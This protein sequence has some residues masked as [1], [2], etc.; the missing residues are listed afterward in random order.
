MASELAEG[1]SSSDRTSADAVIEDL[2]AA[3]WASRILSAAEAMALS[4]V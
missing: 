2:E 3:L 1:V 4:L